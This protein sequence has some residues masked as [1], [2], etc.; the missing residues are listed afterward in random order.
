[1]LDV[2]EMADNGRDTW[3]T[4]QSEILLSFEACRAGDVESSGCGGWSIAVGAA[5]VAVGFCED[6]RRSKIILAVR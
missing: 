5:V 1:M 2:D 3:R 4:V 6:R